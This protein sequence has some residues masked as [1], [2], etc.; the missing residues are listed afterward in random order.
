MVGSVAALVCTPVFEGPFDV[1]LR[2]VSEHKVDICDVP[3]APVIDAFIAEMAAASNMDLEV[4]TEFLV[5]AAILIELKSKKLLPGP[6]QLEDDEELLSGFEERDKLLARLLELQAY[7]GAADCFVTMMDDAARSVPRVA[8]LEEPF[9]EMAPDLLA[10]ITPAR[11]VAAYLRAVIREPAAVLDL[12]HVTVEAVTVSEAVAELEERLP[13]EQRLTFRELSSHCTTRMQVI[14]RFL[15]LLELC[16]RGRVALDQGETFGDLVVTWIA[17][18]G[19][20]S[21]VGGGDGVEEYE[22]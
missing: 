7:A 18:V 19:V 20:L 11:L 6:D 2:L 15:A 4:T 13:C 3:V 5:I 17:N 21:A 12:S 10:G 16:K 22:G 8:G 14:V 9:R 1:L